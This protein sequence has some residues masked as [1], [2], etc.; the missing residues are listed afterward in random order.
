MAGWKSVDEIDAYRLAVEPRDEIGRL[1]DSGRAAKD[2]KFRDQMRD[3]A[4]STTR[5][6]AE[7]FDRYFH[8]EFGYFAGV[9]KGSVGETI[10]ALREGR[11]KGY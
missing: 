7:R 2:F 5:N 3:A 11:A 4:A 1:T 8:G 6:L 9:A 10:D